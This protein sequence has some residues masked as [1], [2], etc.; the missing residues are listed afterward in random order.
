[1]GGRGTIAVE[2][3][4]GPKCQELLALVG[5]IRELADLVPEWHQMEVDQ[6]IDVMETRLMRI[7]AKY[8]DAGRKGGGI[9]D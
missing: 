1:M 3:V 5:D 7:V 6:L 4:M 8:L 9:D 2:I